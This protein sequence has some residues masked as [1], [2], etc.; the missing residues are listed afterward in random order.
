MQNISLTLLAFNLMNEN[1][2]GSDVAILYNCNNVFLSAMA[3]TSST[4][5]SKSPAFLNL[6]TYKF[7]A[8]TLMILLIAL[9]FCV[10]TIVEIIECLPLVNNACN[11]LL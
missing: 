4:H 6:K 9:Y 7:V 2:Y 8:L 1:E 3:E 11:N 10:D 5:A